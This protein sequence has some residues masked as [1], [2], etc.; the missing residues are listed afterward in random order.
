M[1]RV[2]YTD[3]PFSGQAV[4]SAGLGF[5]VLWL[6]I[7][8]E[9]ENIGSTAFRL[10]ASSFLAVMACVLLSNMVQAVLTAPA[11]PRDWSA[12]VKRE[13]ETSFVNLLEPG[14]TVLPFWY[15]RVFSS[16]AGCSVSGVV[17][18]NAAFDSAKLHTIVAF[19]TLAFMGTMVIVAVVGSSRPRNLVKALLSNT[20]TLIRKCFLV[21]FVSVTAIFASIPTFAALVM[22]AVFDVTKGVRAFVFGRGIL[23]LIKIVGATNVLAFWG[24]FFVASVPF[25]VILDVP[26]DSLP[27]IAFFCALLSPAI[28]DVVYLL[29]MFLLFIVDLTLSVVTT[30]RLMPKMSAYGGSLAWNLGSESVEIV[31]KP[32]ATLICEESGAG[33]EYLH[34]Q[35]VPRVGQKAV[36]MAKENVVSSLNC[37]VNGTRDIR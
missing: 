27:I 8:P 10:V 5:L 23:P 13:R 15:A 2:K 29:M 14:R 4:L 18:L 37:D 22:R 21:L 20:L 24:V 19:F 34:D 26:F 25:V 9:E 28:P 1:K 11:E 7:G 33:Y 16:L 3:A 12:W 6:D 32:M 31:T 30:V 17:T 36:V 35:S